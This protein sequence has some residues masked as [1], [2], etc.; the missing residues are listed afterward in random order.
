MKIGITC[1]PSLGGSGVVAAELGK[2]LA[3]RGHIVHFIAS[4]IPFRLGKYNRNIYFHEVEV[5]SYS[6]FRHPP[7]DL[8][9][10]SRMAQ[11]AKMED[12]D[13][14]HVHYAVPHAV[15]AILAKQM[16]GDR[17]K[18][19]TTL[20]GTDI[21]VLGYDR[22]LSDIIRFG[23]ENSDAVSAVSNSLIKQT[24]DLLDVTKP[25][26]LIYNFVD[27]REYYPR[28][29]TM[30]KK[31]YASEEEKLIIHISNFRPV[32]RVSDV[33]KAFAIVKSQLPAKLILIGEGP[34]LSNICAQVKEEG[35]R[36]SVIFL[37]KQDD[38][39]SVISMAD[40]MMLG[41]EKESFGLTALEAMACGVPVVATT[42]GGLPEVVADGETGFL[43]PVGNYEELADK[44]VFLLRNEEMYRRFSQNAVKRAKQVFNHEEIT[45]QY[46]NLYES[47]LNS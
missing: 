12:L 29:V 43:V 16:V 38:I 15:C 45:Q 37:G 42:A 10:A 32:K 30:L 35:L 46:E 14:L 19:V 18:V 4:G 20:H 27:S 11:V 31:E 25:I 17:L 23:I 1:Y 34:E 13:L 3:E 40:I 47:V 33:V 44:A 6:V 8:T 22:G 2:L 39:P 26:N 28:D 21:T 24:I 7:Y 9:L 36:D 5:N 41:S